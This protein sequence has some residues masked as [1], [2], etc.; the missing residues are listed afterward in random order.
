MVESKKRKLAVD[1]ALRRVKR[2]CTSAKQ[3]SPPPPP[4]SPRESPLHK[5]K[6]TKSQAMAQVRKRL[7]HFSTSNLMT[8]DAKFQFQFVEGINELK[9]K[10]DQR[11]RPENIIYGKH[12]TAPQACLRDLGCCGMTTPS[13]G[14]AFQ[15]HI[16]Y[17][18]NH[19]TLIPTYHNAHTYTHTHT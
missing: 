11:F 18:S 12:E 9:F 6:L 15:V 1:T 17:Q 10:D 2:T 13:S 14:Q 4:P 7:R 8:K 19:Q 5:K 16:E 3:E